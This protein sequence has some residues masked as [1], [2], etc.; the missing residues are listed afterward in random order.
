MTLLGEGQR[1]VLEVEGIG[2][3]D[4]SAFLHRARRMDSVEMLACKLLHSSYVQLQ[5][6]GCEP[7]G[8]I[9]CQ[10]SALMFCMILSRVCF[11]IFPRSSSECYPMH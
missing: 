4:I 10:I 9:D 11:T 3:Y 7:A 8:W 1:E 5:G 2:D 6:R